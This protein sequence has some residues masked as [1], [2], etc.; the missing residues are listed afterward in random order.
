ME[1]ARCAMLDAICRAQ[2][3]RTGLFTS[4]HLVMFRERIRI[5]G[6]LISEEEVA[7]GLTTIR[8]LVD[9]RAEGTA[10]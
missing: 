1:K 5:E 10:R 4:P 7:R 8:A 3:I 9:E 6:E 2:G